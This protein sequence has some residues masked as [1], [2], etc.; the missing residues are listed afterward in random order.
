MMYTPEGRDKA[1]IEMMHD[2]VASHRERAASSESFRAIA[3]KHITKAMDLQENGR[4]D[5][6]FNEWVY[7]TQVPRYK[8]DYHVSPANGVKVKL[9]LTV[10]QSE[11]DS[12]FAMFVPI[13]A[14]FGKG[15]I[16][17]A[18]VRLIGNTASTGDLLLPVQPK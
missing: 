11:V 14:D 2:F 18:Q 3:E 4:L 1:F 17:I 13:Y 9:H 10:T 8:F 12:Q 5:W 7:G 15:M 6:F 16:R